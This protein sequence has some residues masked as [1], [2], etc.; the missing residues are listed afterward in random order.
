MIFVSR[1]MLYCAC[2]LQRIFTLDKNKPG[3][4][5]GPEFFGMQ[6]NG[7]IRKKAVMYFERM[8]EAENDQIPY[9]AFDMNRFVDFLEN[10]YGTFTD[11]EEFLHM[12]PLDR[13][14][15]DDYF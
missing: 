9:I 1:E 15:I 14:Y 10:K 3:F 2:R 7:R 5:L 6:V 11:L 4:P 8:M 13:F 12:D